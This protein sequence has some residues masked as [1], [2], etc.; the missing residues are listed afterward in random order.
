MKTLLFVISAEGVLL[1]PCV[2]LLTYFNLSM[3]SVLYYFVIV[4]FFVKL[5]TFYK[6]WTIFLHTNGVFLQIILYFCALEI[7]P[8]L[9]LWGVLGTIVNELK[10]NF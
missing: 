8:L 10:I 1:F 6:C 9:S 4:L 5:L 3:Q 7:I 2:M